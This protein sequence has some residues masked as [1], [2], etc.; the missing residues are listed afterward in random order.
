MK[1]QLK[2]YQIWEFGQRKDAEGRPHQED[3]LFPAYGKV[4]SDD[5]LF[6]LCDGMGGHDAG[7]VASSTVCEAMSQS[8][9]AIPGK[10]AGEF[11]DLD[12]NSALDAAYDALDA[13]D[14]G[15]AKK[16]GTTLAFLDLSAAGAF[17]AHIGDSR[18]YQIRPGKTAADTHI[19]FRTQDHSLVNQL[20][21]AGEITEAEARVHPKKN[22]ITR[23]MQPGISPRPSAS[24][25]VLDDIRPGDYFYLCSDG[26]LEEMTDEQLCYHFS[27]AGGDD[28]RKV[29]NLRLATQ[30]NRDNHTAFII[31]ILD[32]EGAP[33]KSAA[34]VMHEETVRTLKTPAD[35]ASETRTNAT[36]SPR[37]ESAHHASASPKPEKPA[38]GAGKGI[39]YFI[40]A[41]LAIALIVVL[42]FFLRDSATNVE[43]TE[44]EGSELVDSLN[45]SHDEDDDDNDGTSVNKPAAQSQSVAPQKQQAPKPGANIP[46]VK[47][48]NVNNAQTPGASEELKE[49]LKD[50]VQE[51]L[52]R[53]KLKEKQKENEEPVKK[54]DDQNPPKLG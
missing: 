34:P 21:M 30:E 36:H 38:K 14:T 54:D 11:T 12:F 37:Q 17:V 35:A 33:L 25:T 43:E 6:I 50:K 9:S 20:V 42:V 4:N 27:E 23:A 7:E 52:L 48:Q 1:Y 32:V 51:D 26:M 2:A 45:P 16:M 15:A 49:D 13:H 41:L 5:R 3:S 29:R 18:V 24:V 28:E 46:A 47:P 39:L 8:I 44:T 31:H 10:G 40:I 53:E 22:V 19:I